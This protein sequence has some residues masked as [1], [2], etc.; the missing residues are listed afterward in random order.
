MI[1]MVFKS[2]MIHKPARPVVLIRRLR[3]PPAPFSGR[4]VPASSVST[5][6]QRGA[7]NPPL[8][9][10]RFSSEP[11]GDRFLFVTTC[12]TFDP[13][14]KAAT[15]RSGATSYTSPS[16]HIRIAAPLTSRGGWTSAAWAAV[17]TSEF[18][19]GVCIFRGKC[20]S[21]SLVRSTGR[22][23]SARFSAVL[24]L[25]GDSPY[26][27]S[28]KTLSRAS[29]VSVCQ[30]LASPAFGIPLRDTFHSGSFP[31]E[32]RARSLGWASFLPHVSIARSMASR[33][34]E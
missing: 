23:P 29:E 24:K 8:N 25:R 31:L 10:I 30:K 17:T 9:V 1:Q 15:H 2:G 12:L 20:S 16:T 33:S 32:R 22:Q 34:D 14:A 11:P 26:L 7:H 21:R 4:R 6:S 27:S 13:V 28:L 5:N 18:G 3:R 19:A